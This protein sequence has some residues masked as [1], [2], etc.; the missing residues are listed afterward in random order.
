MIFH[1]NFKISKI[2]NTK[3]LDTQTF[4][5]KINL[6][7]GPKFTA[8]RKGA[9]SSKEFVFPKFSKFTINS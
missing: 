6:K 4:G 9:L 3:F 5:W 2:S 8:F 7:S 1:T